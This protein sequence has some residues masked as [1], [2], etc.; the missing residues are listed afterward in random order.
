M[1]IY[2][3]SQMI[4]EKFARKYRK[5]LNVRV[6]LKASKGEIWPIDL[7]G[8]GGE[9][10][11]QNGWP[12]FASCY[13]LRFGHFL[14]FKYQ[15]N[16]H[17]DVFIYDKSGIEIDYPFVST[18]T[19]RDEQDSFNQARSTQVGKRTMIDINELKACKKTRANSAC[20]EP[21]HIGDCWMR[22]LQHQKIEKVTSDKDL[23]V[24]LDD[25]AQPLGMI[26]QT[27]LELNLYNPMHQG[28]L[29]PLLFIS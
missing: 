5:Y 1:S 17:F 22:K 10:W 29:I 21:C 26:D 3:F 8:Y 16:S 25:N 7:V 18:L 2:F 27:K 11:L 9:L 24:K 28:V 14:I 12:E 15:G 19:V 4:P 6:C 23:E 13:S 20:I